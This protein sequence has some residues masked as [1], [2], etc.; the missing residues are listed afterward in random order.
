MKYTSSESISILEFVTDLQLGD[1]NLATSTWVG[2]D[3][4]EALEILVGNQH[5]DEELLELENK[6]LVLRLAF[7]IPLGDDMD[8]VA[9]EQEPIISGT[10]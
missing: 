8:V 7:G 5:C 4:V 9:K 6:I 2:V 3:G 10:V 1:G